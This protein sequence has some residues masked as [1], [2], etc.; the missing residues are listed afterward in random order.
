M[1]GSDFVNL[2]VLNMYLVNELDLTPS[3]V[4]VYQLY[5]GVSAVDLSSASR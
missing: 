2:N 3:F 4:K 1:Q 5:H